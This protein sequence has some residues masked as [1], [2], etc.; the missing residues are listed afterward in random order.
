MSGR[1]QPAQSGYKRPYRGGFGRGYA[2][3]RAQPEV[4]DSKE[5]EPSLKRAVT[6]APA[7][8]RSYHTTQPRMNLGND[9][10]TERVQESKKTAP[11][12]GKEEAFSS[13]EVEVKV[14][15]LRSDG[16]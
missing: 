3:N 9:K 4:D 11:S 12:N 2:T 10:K 1:G 15:H 8:Q 14:I 5:V 6:A 13:S 7:P 16:D